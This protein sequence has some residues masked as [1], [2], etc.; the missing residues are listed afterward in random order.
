MLLFR[1]RF[2]SSAARQILDGSRRKRK[3]AMVIGFVGTGY[4]GLQ[5][6]P[7]SIETEILGALHAAGCV[8]ESNRDNNRKIGWSRTSRTDSNVHAS[9]LVVS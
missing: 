1:S 2:Y 6:N 9:R 5:Q 8:I 7:N 4:S 3:I